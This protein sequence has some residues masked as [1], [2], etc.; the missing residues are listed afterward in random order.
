MSDES[1][2]KIVKETLHSFL[3]RYTKPSTK[4]VDITLF[5]WPFCWKLDT[6]VELDW[7]LDAFKEITTVVVSGD[8][9]MSYLDW[10]D[11]KYLLRCSHKD[12]S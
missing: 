11:K 10:K 12:W 3:N 5:Y 6:D 8:K 7:Y 9:L 4:L 1:K 2:R